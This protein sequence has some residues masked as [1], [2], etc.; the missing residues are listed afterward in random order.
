MHKKTRGSNP[1]H[2]LNVGC[3]FSSISIELL[4]PIILDYKQLIRCATVITAKLYKCFGR[5]D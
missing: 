5:T 1:F 3:K 2:N 4:H